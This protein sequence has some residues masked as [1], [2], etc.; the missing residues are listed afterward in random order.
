ME[1]GQRL[2]KILQIVEGGRPGLKH[3][4]VKAKGG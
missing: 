1:S 4:R 3:Q 2:K